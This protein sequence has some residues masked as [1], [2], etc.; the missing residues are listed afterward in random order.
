VTSK[1]ILQLIV[2]RQRHAPAT[3][4]LAALALLAWGRDSTEEFVQ[5]YQKP[6]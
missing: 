2:S 1:G 3:G 4:M 5:K 6:L